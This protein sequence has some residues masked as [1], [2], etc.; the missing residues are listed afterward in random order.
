MVLFAGNETS[1]KKILKQ[2]QKSCEEHEIKINVNKTRKK[3]R[4]MA[5][6][7]EINEIFTVINIQSASLSPAFLS[8]RLVL[9]SICGINLFQKLSRTSFTTLNSLKKIIENPV[10]ESNHENE[11]LTH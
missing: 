7:M 8:L 5:Q 6:H 4:K 3:E 1:I 10:V 9:F 11:S 2:P